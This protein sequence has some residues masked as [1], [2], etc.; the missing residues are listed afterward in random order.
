MRF[1]RWWLS[2]GSGV[3][4]G[5]VA[6]MAARFFR[7]GEDRG[8]EE[9]EMDGEASGGRRGGLRLMRP[10][11]WDRGRRMAASAHPRGGMV[12]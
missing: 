7:L 10:N 8:K 6:A 3:V 2:C 9:E 11:R 5:G 1:G 12:L 4:A